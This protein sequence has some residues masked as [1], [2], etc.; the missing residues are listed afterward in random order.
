MW[1]YYELKTI[2]KTCKFHWTPWSITLSKL[3]DQYCLYMYLLGIKVMKFTCFF[4]KFEIKKKTCK[5]W[6]LI[7]EGVDRF[8]YRN[9]LILFIF[10]WR[11]KGMKC[12][13]YLKIYMNSMAFIT[14]GNDLKLCEILN[15]RH[16]NFCEQLLNDWL[17]YK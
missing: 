1:D 16:V 7:V 6:C 12:T 8:C 4:V 5:I 2:T 14:L 3:I 15:W 13:R 10:S 17:L 9:W 11:Q